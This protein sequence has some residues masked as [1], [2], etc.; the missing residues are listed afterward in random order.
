[1]TE[2]PIIIEMNI[3]H[4]GAML[5]LDLGDKQRSIIE[6]LLAQAKANLVLAIDSRKPPE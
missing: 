6:Q 4:Y 3:S 2:E 1:M 5:K